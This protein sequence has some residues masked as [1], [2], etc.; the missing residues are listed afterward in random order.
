M[1]TDATKLTFECSFDNESPA[2]RPIVFD[3]SF[4][5]LAHRRLRRAHL[6]RS[7][8]RASSAMSGSVARALPDHD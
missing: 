5:C 8:M 2:Y 7:T 4:A 6:R 1:Q 3:A